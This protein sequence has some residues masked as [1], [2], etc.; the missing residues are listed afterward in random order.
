MFGDVL[1]VGLR[2][3]FLFALIIY[4]AG[5]ATAIYYQAPNLEK[6]DIMQIQS[7][8]KHESENR[9]TSKAE[10][11]AKKVHKD[12]RKYYSFAEEKASKVGSLIK[13]RL[14]EQ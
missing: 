7:K 2:G 5:F 4:F 11:L 12:L 14:D 13:A 1:M 8:D 6:S 3:K 10:V 9:E